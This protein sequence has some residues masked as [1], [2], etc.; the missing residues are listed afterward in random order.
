MYLNNHYIVEQQVKQKEQQI[1]PYYMWRFPWF[2]QL[3]GS[4]R[5]ARTDPLVRIFSM[6]DMKLISYSYLN[7]SWYLYSQTIF[8]LKAFF[9]KS[10]V[11]CCPV[12]K[13]DQ[14]NWNIKQCS[15]FQGPQVFGVSFE[16]HTKGS[17]KSTWK[18]YRRKCKSTSSHLINAF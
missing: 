3:P 15:S 6:N 17:L 5:S 11:V 8:F 12:H 18:R 16:I 9:L 7:L 4:L 10:Y 2:L 13:T 14:F 1:L